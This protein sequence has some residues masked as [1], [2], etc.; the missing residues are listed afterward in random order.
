MAGIKARLDRLARTIDFGRADPPLWDGGKWG[1]LMPALMDGRP[2]P[3]GAER[4]LHAAL[5]DIA[6]ANILDDPDSGFSREWRDRMGIPEFADEDA[7]IRCA[8]DNARSLGLT[9]A[10]LGELWR[11]IEDRPGRGRPPGCSP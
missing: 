2:I 8:L 1:P 7:V 6:V 11:W 9:P 3:P 10:E 5:I 4:A